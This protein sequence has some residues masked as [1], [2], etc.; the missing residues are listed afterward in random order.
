MIEMVDAHNDT[1]DDTRDDTRR[2][3]VGA[4]TPVTSVGE[5]E[6]VA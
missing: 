3:R 1:W 6:I 4:R 2:V 5:P